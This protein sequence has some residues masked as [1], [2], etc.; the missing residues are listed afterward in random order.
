[1]AEDAVAEV[2]AGEGW[3]RCGEVNEWWNMGEVVV[4]LDY[5]ILTFCR[6]DCMFEKYMDGC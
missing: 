3:V 5:T 4:Y 1:M 2:G 6:H